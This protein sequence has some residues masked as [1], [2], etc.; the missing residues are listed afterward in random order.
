VFGSMKVK[1][2]RNASS[3]IIGT[4]KRFEG[5]IFF[6]F[7]NIQYRLPAIISRSAKKNTK[8]LIEGIRRLDK[9]NSGK[10]VEKLW[11]K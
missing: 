9:V 7:S 2:G 4:T 8:R 3:N 11:K 6:V 1:V 5:K 10:R